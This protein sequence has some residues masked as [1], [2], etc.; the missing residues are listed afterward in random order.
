VPGTGGEPRALSLIYCL[1]PCA[2]KLASAALL[3]ISPIEPAGGVA[4]AEGRPA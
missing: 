1:L 2:F 3:W 4:R